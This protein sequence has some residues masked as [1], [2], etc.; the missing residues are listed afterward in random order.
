MANLRFDYVNWHGRLH[1][2]VVEPESI[3]FDINHAE[4]SH[5]CKWLLH[6]TVVTRDGDPRT[7][8]MGDN[9]RRSFIFER[10][11]SISQVDR[12]V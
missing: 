11:R 9:R 7:E 3:E 5:R 2:Y 8:A 4:E 10:L 12:S 1:T 6:A